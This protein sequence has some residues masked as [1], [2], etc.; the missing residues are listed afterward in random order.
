MFSLENQYSE[1]VKEG[2]KERKLFIDMGT[3]KV[4]IDRI[5]FFRNLGVILLN[6]VLSKFG[7]YSFKFIFPIYR[8]KLT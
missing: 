8:A 3:V 5:T 6:T 2:E 7:V 4:G 1:R